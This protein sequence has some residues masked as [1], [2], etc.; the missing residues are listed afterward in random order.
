MGIIDILTEFGCAKSCEY[1]TKSLIT[2]SQGMSCV[3]PSNYQKRFLNF[4]KNCF[5]DGELKK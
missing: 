5:V 3:P 4:M 2:C 1:I